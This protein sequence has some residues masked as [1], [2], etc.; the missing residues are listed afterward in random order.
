MSSCLPL[1]LAAAEWLMLLS[2]QLLQPNERFPL[3]DMSH[4]LERTI[5]LLYNAPARRLASRND[6]SVGA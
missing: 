6:A 5:N 2:E 4:H 1:S 3:M